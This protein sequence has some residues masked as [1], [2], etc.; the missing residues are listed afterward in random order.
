M[1]K[2]MDKTKYYFKETD[3]NFLIQQ[4]MISNKLTMILLIKIIKNNQIIK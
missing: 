4:I 3:N 1:I 2:M